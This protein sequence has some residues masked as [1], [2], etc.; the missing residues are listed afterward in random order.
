[1]TAVR[2]RAPGKWNWTDQSAGARARPGGVGRDPEGTE[3]D[4][5]VVVRPNSTGL[6]LS[7]HWR[8]RR[9]K[10]REG[11]GGSSGSVRKCRGVA[12]VA[13]AGTVISG[14]PK[15]GHRNAPQL[16]LID[17]FALLSSIPGIFKGIS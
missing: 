13:A 16:A 9:R 14:R 4:G 11:R 5:T 17:P 10:R 8:F 7:A 12:A 1:M 6:W 2:A 3:G 15:E